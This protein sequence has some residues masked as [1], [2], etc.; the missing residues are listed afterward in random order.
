MP[1]NNNY[2]H[3]T[4]HFAHQHVVT[5]ATGTTCAYLGDERGLREHLVADEATRACAKQAIRP[6]PS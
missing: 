1:H 6:A 3:V 2:S 5:I 4:Q